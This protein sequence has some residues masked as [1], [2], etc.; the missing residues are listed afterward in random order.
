MKLTKE[1]RHKYYKLA[2]SILLEK[3]SNFHICSILYRLID[4]EEWPNAELFPEFFAKRPTT[5]CPDGTSKWWTSR[6]K[7]SRIKVLRACIRETAP[8]KRNKVS[9]QTK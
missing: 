5:P 8:K 4:L 6:D 9:N 1:K 2:L 3:S 7:K